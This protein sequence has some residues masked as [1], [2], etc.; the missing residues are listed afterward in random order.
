[1]EKVK[2]KKQK[3]GRKWA[4]PTTSQGVR[5]PVLSD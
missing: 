4:K 1:M 2:K 5:R 3:N